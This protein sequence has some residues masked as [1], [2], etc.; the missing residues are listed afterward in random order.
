MNDGS[1]LRRKVSVRAAERRRAYSFLIPALLLTAALFSLLGCLPAQADGGYVTD[2]AGIFSREEQLRLETD[3]AAISEQYG[4]GVY[5][6][7]LDDWTQENLS[8]AGSFWSFSTNWYRNQGLGLGTE[9]NGILLILSMADR[10]Y[11][12]LAYGS[13]AHRAFTDFGKEQLEK[14]F[15]D[16]FRRNDWYGGAADYLSGCGRLLALYAQGTPLDVSGSNEYYREN[17]REN[18]I[19]PLIV[20]GAPLLISLLVCGGM[21]RSMKPVKRKMTAEDY[22]APSGLN[23]SRRQDV[24]LHRSVTRRVIRRDPPPGAGHSGGGHMGGTTIHSGGF[25][26]HSGKF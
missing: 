8:G 2:S 18:P 4:I 13:D 24:F 25:S 21:K 26:G 3:A 14:N 12:L 9:R 19:T 7:F 16:N 1:A 5:L 22:V 10:D 23:L 20:F 17:L 6:A 11:S 15:L